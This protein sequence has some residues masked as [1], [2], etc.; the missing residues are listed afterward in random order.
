MLDETIDNASKN[1]NSTHSHLKI[2]LSGCG[3]GSK[4]QNYRTSI[5]SDINESSALPKSN[6]EPAFQEM[7]LN[8]KFS[9]EENLLSSTKYKASKYN[10]AFSYE[11]ESSLP[12][13]VLTRA[14]SSDYKKSKKY[15]NDLKILLNEQSVAAK[16]SNLPPISV[17]STN[18]YINAN[19]FDGEMSNL[20]GHQ[21]LNKFDTSSKTEP[22]DEKR[23]DPKRI[24]KVIK[25]SLID[26]HKRSMWNLA[27]SAQHQ[28]HLQHVHRQKLQQQQ[29]RRLFNW[30]L[31]NSNQTAPEKPSSNT[32][33]FR[34]KSVI[35]LTSHNKNSNPMTNCIE[36]SLKRENIIGA[37]SGLM[38]QPTS[39]MLS[40]FSQ[41]SYHVSANVIRQ[42][43][44]KHEIK[45][46]ITDNF[47]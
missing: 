42:S 1:R 37:G 26:L 2:S 45:M 10:T 41:A 14:K 23:L 12:P 25:K 8:G 11:R 6:S 7:T 4:T 30:T 34:K 28:E 31:G 20:R 29:H 13:L 46:K 35:N 33:D 27:H 40:S 36:T 21:M 32:T 38:S 9:G 5:D 22:D 17:Y 16:S 15:D 47:S 39:V 24:P 43:N 3:S 18:E 44:P 19:T